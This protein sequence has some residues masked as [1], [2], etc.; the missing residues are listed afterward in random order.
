MAVDIILDFPRHDALARA[1]RGI[2]AFIGAVL[3]LVAVVASALPI[4]V[5]S[6]TV[7]SLVSGKELPEFDAELVR[8]LAVATAIMIVGFT[9]GLKLVRGRRRLVLFLR[10]FGFVPATRLLSFAVARAAGRRWRLATLDDLQVAAVGVQKRVR[11]IAGSVG[12]IGLTIIVLGAIWIFGGAFDRFLTDAMDQATQTTGNPIDDL[13]AAIGGAFAG[14][15]VAGIVLAFVVLVM[16]LFGATTLFAVG[17]YR[18]VR[19]V[20][21]SRARE[22]RSEP[23]IVPT[24]RSVS[25]GARKTFGA[26]LVVVRVNSAIWK[27]V[28]AELA[29]NSSGIV[30]DV[31]QPTENLLWEVAAIKPHFGSR[32]ILVGRRDQVS[33]WASSATSGDQGAPAAQLAEILDG[34]Q[35]LAYESEDR[36]AMKRFA[37]GLRSKLEELR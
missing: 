14:A 27:P 29:R 35:I 28:V 22:I 26:R 5:L 4:L 31:S 2:I 21:R 6:L 12:L 32:W 3:V 24:V 9:I 17:S 36:S 34:E 37:K 15:I 19:R 13:G 10:R 7:A 8:P 18:S 11:W 30:I 25:R 16:S 23:E 20:E 33:G 1:G